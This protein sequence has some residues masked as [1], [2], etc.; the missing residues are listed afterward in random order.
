MEIFMMA[1]GL[2]ASKTDKESTTMQPPKSFIVVSGK[3]VKRMD[4]DC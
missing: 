1:N 4:M 2:M 3:T